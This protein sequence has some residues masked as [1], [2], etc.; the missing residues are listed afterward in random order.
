MVHRGLFED[1]GICEITAEKGIYALFACL[2]GKM[3]VDQ[4]CQFLFL[5]AETED[6]LPKLLFGLYHT[7]F[8]L[9]LGMSPTKEE[10]N[11]GKYFDAHFCH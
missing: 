1:I 10:L 5:I 8:E 9:F 2:W 6:K 3:A 4:F 11:L 7:Y